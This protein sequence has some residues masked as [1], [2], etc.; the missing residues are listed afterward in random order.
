MRDDQ[1][2]GVDI[3]G[4][5]V[6]C[7]APVRIRIGDACSDRNIDRAGAGMDLA[8]VMEDRRACIAMRL[9]RARIIGNETDIAVIRGDIRVD[10]DAAACLEG[11]MTAIAARVVADDVAENRD[12]VVRLQGHIGAGIGK[13]G[14]RRRR[15]R[16]V[17]IG[18]LVEGIV[19]RE[20]I[21]ARV[22]D[23]DVLRVEQQQTGPA[24]ARAGIDMA[25]EAQPFL[26]RNLDEA[27]VPGGAA[28]AR[29]DIAVITRN[30]VGPD[31][32]PAAVAV[33]AAV[34][35]DRCAGADMGLLGVHDGRVLA[36]EIAADQ[37]LAAAVATAG[38]DKCVAHQAN[39]RA[40][41]FDVTALPRR[42]RDIQ[43]AAAD[44]R[45][46]AAGLE[47]NATAIIGD[48]RRADDAAVVDRQRVDV[49]ARRLQLG[50]RRRDQAAVVDGIAVGHSRRRADPQA[51]A[52][53][54]AQQYLRTGAETGDAIRL[55]DALVVDLRRDQE[56]IA[57]EAA[58]RAEVRDAG[59]LARERQV[60]AV[61]EVL[62]RE[63]EGAGN[64][65][66]GIDDAGRADQHAVRVDQ[67]DLAV[68]LEF[69][70]DSRRIA[71]DHA[72][73]HRARLAG[74][75]EAGQVPVGD[76]EVLPVDNRTFADLVDREIAALAREICHAGNQL[77]ACRRRDYRSC[78]AQRQHQQ[79]AEQP[80]RDPRSSAESD[81]IGLETR[82]GR[83]NRHQ[84][85]HA[86]LLPGNTH[87]RTP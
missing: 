83:G 4:H 48:G 45:A 47:E 80:S 44:H 21:H 72:V 25:G 73:Q 35:A 75:H 46:A 66:A 85:S 3:P 87:N 9:D 40:G 28:A 50:L 29:A 43:R 56:Y 81:D 16:D 54:V 79:T 14:D 67:E 60:T 55:D 70:E 53:T 15:D 6:A 22:R 38:I 1:I 10:A 69:A 86:V 78:E 34:G 49:A 74:L 61:H 23:D 8:V 26:A 57:A 77:F 32:D 27:A 41:H 33:D 36:L 12:V 63:I 42:R 84:L 11:Q 59:A 68:A 2:R 30:A 18:V 31:D 19:I 52:A 51:L 24:V 37:H 62:V 58:D 65:T 64:E 20:H 76:R 39:P 5:Q 17:L 13:R 7:R 82:P 71:R